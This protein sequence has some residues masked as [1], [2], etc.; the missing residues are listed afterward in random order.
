MLPTPLYGIFFITNTKSM[1][2]ISIKFEMMR[3]LT[4]KK[5]EECQSSKRTI[6]G[7]LENIIQGFEACQ[8][9]LKVKFLERR[10]KK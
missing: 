8:T 5:E 7:R 10:I 4:C 6:L 9:F 1:H 2:D 3:S